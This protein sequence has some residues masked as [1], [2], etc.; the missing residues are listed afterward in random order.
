MRKALY[1]LS[2]LD[3][4]DVDWMIRNGRKITV[5]PGTLL[6]EQGKDDRIGCT[7]SWTAPS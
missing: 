1:F 7:S 2:I 6:I 4:R 5:S 3:D